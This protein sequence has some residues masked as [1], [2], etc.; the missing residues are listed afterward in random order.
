[1]DGVT[2]AERR[3]DLLRSDQ[4]LTLDEVAESIRTSRASVYRLLAGGLASYKI[5]GFRRVL[6]EDLV[7]FLEAHREVPL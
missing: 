2:T 6:V 4:W 7:V 1:M 3:V 5:G